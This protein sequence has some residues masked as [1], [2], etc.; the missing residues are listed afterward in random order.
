MIFIFGSKL[1][2]QCDIVPG[3]FHVATRFGH[4]DYI[5]LIPRQSYIIL[6][7]KNTLLGRTFRGVPIGIS[8]Y[9]IAIAWMRCLSIGAIV[10]E[11]IIMIAVG[12]R[13]DQ[14]SVV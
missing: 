6:D 2:G 10:L 7:Q 4:F 14:K 9:S 1:F 5:P 12:S 8:G 3:F 11:L 13:K